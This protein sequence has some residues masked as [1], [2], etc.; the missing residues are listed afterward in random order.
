MTPIV[1]KELYDY[2]PFATLY[3]KY[4]NNTWKNNYNNERSSW[5]NALLDDP[6]SIKWLYYGRG[7]SQKNRR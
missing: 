6:R 2:R 3:I 4:N 1:N 5:R 7:A